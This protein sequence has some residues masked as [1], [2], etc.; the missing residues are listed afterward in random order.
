MDQALIDQP[1]CLPRLAVIRE[2]RALNILQVHPQV[3][4]VIFVHEA[5]SRGTCDD[6]PALA[7][8]EYRSAEGFASRMLEDDIGVF[9]AGEFPDFLAEAPPLAGIL[10]GVVFPESIV[11]GT[12]VD[13]E[14]GAHGTGA[15]GLLRRRI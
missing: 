7:R 9:A 1:V 11:F 2:M 5:R 10:S 8:H 15:I 14:I 12:P 6:R 3:P 13:D 4:V